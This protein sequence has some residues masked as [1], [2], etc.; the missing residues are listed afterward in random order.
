MFSCFS[1]LPYRYRTILSMCFALK[2]SWVLFSL[3]VYLD[4]LLFLGLIFGFNIFCSLYGINI[5]AGNMQW[6]CNLCNDNIVCKY[7]IELLK[8]ECDLYSAECKWKDDVLND[9]EECRLQVKMKMMM[10]VW[11]WKKQK[12]KCRMSQQIAIR[13]G[14]FISHHYYAPKLKPLQFGHKRR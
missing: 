14:S 1:F 7:S 3:N 8:K 2:Q 4:G 5:N 6:V 10:T 11:N 12:W 13:L 9:A